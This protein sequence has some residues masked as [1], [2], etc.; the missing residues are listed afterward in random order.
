MRDDKQMGTSV[1]MIERHY[2][3]L[4]VVRAVHHLHSAESRQLIE[5][6]ALVDEKYSYKPKQRKKRK[7]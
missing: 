5:S 1:G 4:D 3:H 2:S 7:R 6:T